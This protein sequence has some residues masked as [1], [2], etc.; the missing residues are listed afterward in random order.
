MK[1]L[2]NPLYRMWVRRY[3]AKLQGGIC[4]QTLIFEERS[5]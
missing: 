1:R 4:L 3:L 5:D 2:K